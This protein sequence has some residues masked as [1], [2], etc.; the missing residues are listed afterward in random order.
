MCQPGFAACI[1]IYSMRALV[2][3]AL[4]AA[5][6]TV[7]NVLEIEMK[8]GALTKRQRGSAC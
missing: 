4:A 6:D 1:A 5:L 8:T 7:G 3:L 2:R